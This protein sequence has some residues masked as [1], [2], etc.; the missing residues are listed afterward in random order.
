MEKINIQE[1]IEENEREIQFLSINYKLDS[2]LVIM[3]IAVGIILLPAY[4]LF[5]FALPILFPL[6]ILAV[7]EVLLVFYVS[8]LNFK[9]YN[10]N[11]P[12]IE[13]GEMH[14]FGVDCI[15]KSVDAR[16]AD[17]EKL[18]EKML[19][20]IVEELSIASGISAPKV[21]VIPGKEINSFSITE[22]FIFY[23]ESSETDVGKYSS[24]CVTEG[25]L[26]NL[27]RSELSAIVAHEIAHIR[28][29]D[30]QIMSL[31]AMERL[32]YLY[33][34]SKLKKK[35][36]KGK[37][38]LIIKYIQFIS[39]WPIT[40]GRESDFC[41]Y[42]KREIVADLF[43]T[44][45]TK[46]PQ[47]L[48]SVLKKIKEINKGELNVCN[49]IRHMFFVDPNKNPSESFIP[50]QPSIDERIKYLESL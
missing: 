10:D 15:L 41:F 45:L 20:D 46:N 2:I 24:I 27:N 49:V 30:S 12:R 34:W 19:V 47:A 29:K 5:L 35:N 32:G 38:N 8:I 28:N 16:D 40:R 31:L 26:N 43:S 25:A 37:Y 9:S 7:V 36:E 23:T 18:K 1:I 33:L 4:I 42:K 13:K 14:S 50:T 17:K 44:Y 39:S 22:P 21:Y 11:K 48:I 3:G 6:V